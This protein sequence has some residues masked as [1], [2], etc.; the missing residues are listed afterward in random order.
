MDSL[1][2][3]GILAIGAPNRPLLGINVAEGKTGMI[4]SGGMNPFAAMSEAGVSVEIESLSCLEHCSRFSHFEDIA[5]R[6]RRRSP[7][8]D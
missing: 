5:R 3:G 2:L 8:I 1:G 6:G 7:F 4:V